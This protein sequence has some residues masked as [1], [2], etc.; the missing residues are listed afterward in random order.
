VV[1]VFHRIDRP[2]GGRSTGYHGRTAP[3]ANP[4]VFKQL[5]LV[6]LRLVTGQ[7]GRQIATFLVCLTPSSV[8]LMAVAYSDV[9]AEA[10]Q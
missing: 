7:S 1:R 2:E 10:S 3:I 4:C 8:T 6:H 5:G 9:G